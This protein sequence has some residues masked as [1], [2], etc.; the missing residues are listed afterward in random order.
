MSE[1][2]TVAAPVYTGTVLVVPPVVVT[3]ICAVAV[4]A[5][6]AMQNAST[7]SD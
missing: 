4:I 1:L 2:P 5:K 6:A 7:F 3:A